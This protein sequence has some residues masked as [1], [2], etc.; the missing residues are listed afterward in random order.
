MLDPEA[1]LLG[2]L[3]FLIPTVLYSCSSV[4]YSLCLMDVLVDPLLL[5]APYALFQLMRPSFWSVCLPAFC[6]S[7]YVTCGV[8]E[9]VC[10][11][12]TVQ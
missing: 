8:I 11:R 6:L 3:A 10:L 1:D 4:D 12:K 7:V 9:F 5:A 2:V